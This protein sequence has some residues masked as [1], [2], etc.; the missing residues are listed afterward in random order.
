MRCLGFFKKKKKKKKNVATAEQLPEVLIQQTQTITD[1]GAIF[2][3]V[4]VCV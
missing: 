2:V 1:Y 4:C 3:C